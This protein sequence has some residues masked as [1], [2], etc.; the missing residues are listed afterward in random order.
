MGDTL[1]YKFNASVDP[2][3]SAND[4]LAWQ[5]IRLGRRRGLTRLDFGLSDVAQP[6]L[7]R[8]KRKY[9]TEERTIAMLRW[10]PPGHADARSEQARQTFGRM[11]ELL[12]HPAVPDEITAAAGDQ[13]YQFFC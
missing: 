13:L 7:I 8:Y 5:G 3:F 12:T 10:Q 6:G 2:Q 4:L 11:T 9:A 1:Y